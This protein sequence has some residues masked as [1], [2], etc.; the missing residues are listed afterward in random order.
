M[1]RFPGA[2]RTRTSLHIGQAAPFSSYFVAVCAPRLRTG[3]AIRADLADSGIIGTAPWNASDC[4]SARLGQ[5]PAEVRTP[6]PELV[7]HRHRLELI[8]KAVVTVVD[9]TVGVRWKKCRRAASSQTQQTKRC[10]PGDPSRETAHA[11]VAPS[12]PRIGTV[13]KQ[14]YRPIPDGTLE[15]KRRES[16]GFLP[17]STL[18]H[19]R[20]SRLGRGPDRPFPAGLRR[21]A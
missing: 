1:P 15:E 17:I 8:A 5:P 18:E 3:R 11:R 20:G 14:V 2:E 13:Q 9:G 16:D 7:E 19:G 10:Q 4:G 12:A 6:S 21:R